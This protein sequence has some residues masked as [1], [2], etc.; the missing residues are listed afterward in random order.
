MKMRATG[1][2][3][4]I[5]RQKG[6]ELDFSLLEAIEE[7]D[8]DRI[9]KVWKAATPE[10]R[11]AMLIKAFRE[12]VK[13]GKL[14]MVNYL[15][16]VATLE[17]RNAMLAAGNALDNA[18]DM[19]V[20]G[21][22]LQVVKRLLEIATPKQRA[23]MLHNNTVFPYSPIIN[24]AR[25]F[26]NSTAF[27]SPPINNATQNCFL[28]IIKTLLAYIS[29]TTL[30]TVLQEIYNDHIID[31][32][33]KIKLNSL[34]FQSE[35]NNFQQALA[36]SNSE[37]FIAKAALKEGNLLRQE[38][39]DIG[40]SYVLPTVKIVIEYNRPSMSRISV[41]LVDIP[42]VHVP[43]LEV[44]YLRVTDAHSSISLPPPPQPSQVVTSAN[45]L[46]R[47][48]MGLPPL[49]SQQP[50]VPPTMSP[51]LVDKSAS[52]SLSNENTSKANVKKPEGSI[53]AAS[54]ISLKPLSSSLNNE[55]A[56][57]L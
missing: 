42:H 41:Q 55:P 35:L 27:T 7:D 20:R 50:A 32:L 2:I 44:S 10:Q 37:M 43:L 46:L 51:S 36:A 25:K 3:D 31:F 53:T 4:P 57:R 49:P 1:F 5:L 33:T 11:D 12:A 39:I 47:E 18:L 9:R 21:G 34:E 29:D 26:R 19:A 56:A 24:A 40:G 30:K 13:D 45:A 6:E 28:E 54:S 14:G 22:Y 15:F 17:Q 38:L 23:A 16:G 8:Q 48:A 52:S